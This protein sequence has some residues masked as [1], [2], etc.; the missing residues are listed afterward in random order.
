MG[1]RLQRQFIRFDSPA[2][3]P[4]DEESVDSRALLSGGGGVGKSFILDQF[5]S[6][7]LEGPALTV[8]APLGCCKVDMYVYSFGERLH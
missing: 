5:G 2:P 3:L 8:N 6:G 7:S 4:G 1:Q